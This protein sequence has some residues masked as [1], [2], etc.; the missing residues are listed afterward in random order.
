[1]L[2]RF[3]SVSK[4]IQQHDNGLSYIVKDIRHCNFCKK[5]GHDTEVCFKKKKHEKKLTLAK[6]DQDPKPVKWC[7]WCKM[8]NHNDEDCGHLK[9]KNQSGNSSNQAVQCSKKS[10]IERKRSDVQTHAK[11]YKAM[12]CC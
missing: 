1:M 4:I 6:S 10:K 12:F 5:D 11:I 9:R 2:L 7:S 3:I 8:D